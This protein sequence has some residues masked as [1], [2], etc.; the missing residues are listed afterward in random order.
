MTLRVLKLLTEKNVHLTI[1]ASN[2]AFEYMRATRRP[3]SPL[4]RR[5]RLGSLARLFTPES[6]SAIASKANMNGENFLQPQHSPSLQSLLTLTIEKP[7]ILAEVQTFNDKVYYSALKLIDY[8]EIEGKLCLISH[9]PIH[10]EL[11]VLVAKCLGVDT[12]KDTTRDNLGE[13]VQQL[14]ATQD[15]LKSTLDQINIAFQGAVRTGSIYELINGNVVQEFYGFCADDAWQQHPIAAVMW[16]RY[17]HYERDPILE[18]HP[19]IHYVHG[20]T[21]TWRDDKREML[22]AAGVDDRIHN[23]DDDNDLGKTK[24]HIEGPITYLTQD[25]GWAR[26][27]EHMVDAE[28]RSSGPQI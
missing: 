26:K 5:L 11:I 4:P 12:Y 17:L 7:E 9:A 25:R 27:I 3:Q 6:E 19:N 23:L 10:S 20:H 13:K 21:G 18:K 1:M 14:I 8:C 24:D 2:H 28:I 22:K 15:H 16:N